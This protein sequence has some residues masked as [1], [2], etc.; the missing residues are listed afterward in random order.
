ML[1]RIK[2]WVSDRTERAIASVHARRPTKPPEPVGKS[3]K[4]FASLSVPGP[5]SA[6]GPS[7]WSVNKLECVKHYKSAAYVAI[8][9]TARKIAGQ[10]IRVGT[11]TE[12]KSGLVKEPV[13]WNHPLSELYRE[14]NSRYTE[15][16]M[17]FMTVAWLFA[18]GDS[19]LWKNRNGLKLPAELWPIPSQWVYPM[20]SP[21]KFIG[22]Y[23]IVGAWGQ[24]RYID[25]EDVVQHILPALDWSGGGRFTGWPTMAA[26]AEPIDNYEAIVKRLWHH[27]RNYT[28]PGLHFDVPRELTPPELEQ[29][30]A[31]IR[32]M[33]ALSE[34]A[35]TPIV[36][37]GGTKLADFSRTPKE[38][39][40]Y[41]SLDAMLDIVLAV[42]M[43]PRAAVGISREYNRANYEAAM[44]AWAENSINPM[45][46]SIGQRH[47]KD[48][49]REFDDRLVVW[50]DPVTLDDAAKLRDDIRVAREAKAITPNEVRDLLFEKESYKRGGD[51]PIIAPAEVEAPFGNMQPKLEAEIVQEPNTAAA[52]I[53]QVS[54]QHVMAVTQIVTAVAAGTMPR[55]AGLGQLT[56]LFG[57]EQS[58]AEAIMGSAGQ[59]KE[60]SEPP[61][62]SEPLPPAIAERMGLSEEE[63]AWKSEILKRIDYAIEFERRQGNGK[64]AA[65]VGAV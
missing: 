23:W 18:C 12:R 49:A 45:L 38:M 50:F 1:N 9:A 8:G 55:D 48:L 6:A 59:E 19:Y 31:N 20:P 5:Y 61:K 56:T 26:A 16:E 36:T 4:E 32:E 51:A 39:D 27:M 34:N 62:Q 54:P 10:T 13:N 60:E 2:S 42:H 3:L 46:E 63:K 44:L 29:A 7:N 28:P 22:Q 21:T 57:L 11:W 33:V 58:D 25:A 40:Y 64:L 17:W 53:S 47:T 15:W 30:Y 35:G 43:T 37:H 65:Q 14:W 52:L 41:R 24:A